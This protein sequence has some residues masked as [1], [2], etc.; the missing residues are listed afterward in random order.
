MQDP[1]QQYP[2]KQPPRHQHAFDDFQDDDT[3]Q[4]VG[5]PRIQQAPLHQRGMPIR[6]VLPRRRLRT[7][8]AI[9]LAAGIIASLLS[10]IVTLANGELYRQAAQFASNPSRL[11]ISVATTI[12]GLFCLT[13]VISL[14]LYFVAGFITGKVTVDRRMGFLSGFAAG[15][16]AQ[17]IG[18]IVQYIP[19]YPGTVNSGINGG[20][21][22][23][24]GGTI[25]AVVVLLVVALIA[26]LI[27][28]LGAWLAT[29]RHPYYVGYGE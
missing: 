19:N 9:A 4:P 2:L 10:I 17:V 1:D 3:V 7:T 26:G 15:V 12:F 13:S 23:L 29:R 8:L 5:S 27:G 24:S 25:V 14:A 22:G 20:F 6:P 28:F 21:I 16:I 18:F 11:P